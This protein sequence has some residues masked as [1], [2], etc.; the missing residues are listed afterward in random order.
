MVRIKLI[1]TYSSI[2]VL[3]HCEYAS[4]AP[5]FYTAVKTL[6][7]YALFFSLGYLP[8][9]RYPLFSP[10]HARK[11]GCIDGK[12]GMLAK[13]NCLCGHL[14]FHISHLIWDMKCEISTR[15]WASI[16]ISMPNTSRITP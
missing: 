14:I 1:N 11:G 13:S 12:C 7:A 16:F 3:S 8:L 6:L 15:Y 9:G 10:R 2:F 4:F 5:A